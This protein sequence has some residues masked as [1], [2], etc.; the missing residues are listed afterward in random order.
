MV[1]VPLP[2]ATGENVPAT[3]PAPVYIPPKGKPP[4]S[5]KEAEVKQTD[6]KDAKDTEGGGKITT[7]VCVNEPHPPLLY[8]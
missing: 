7:L 3:I 2:A 8:V 5:V 1:W 4:E 6:E